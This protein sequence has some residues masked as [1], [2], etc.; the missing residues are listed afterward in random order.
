MLSAENTTIGPIGTV[1]AQTIEG[2]GQD[3]AVLF[4]ESGIELGALR[5]P[6]CTYSYPRHAKAAWLGG[7]ALQ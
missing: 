3:P 4:A 6:Q 5:D 1:I 2:S 7:R